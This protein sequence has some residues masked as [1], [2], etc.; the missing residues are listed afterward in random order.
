MLFAAC[1]SSGGDQAARVDEGAQQPPPQSAQQATP[2]QA[3]L[4]AKL[5]ELLPQAD[6]EKI[7]GKALVEQ[8]NDDAGCH[9]RD[10]KGT[11]GTGVSLDVNILTVSDQCRLVPKSEPLSGVGSEACIAVGVPVGL[12]TTVVFNSGGQTFEAT[13]PGQDRASQKATAVAR[14]VLAKRGS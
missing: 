8:R 2:Q 9:Y 11:E 1:G 13:A 6:A 12:Y 14:V 5:C 7:M 10:A 4:P 3:A